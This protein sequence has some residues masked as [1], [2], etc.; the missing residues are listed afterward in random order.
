M[1]FVLYAASR[2]KARLIP[3][4]PQTRALNT[5]LPQ[6][7]KLVIRDKFTLPHVTY[8]G[9]DQG[10]GCGFRYVPKES[11]DLEDP[12]S[13][14]SEGIERQNET[15]HN[16]QQLRDYLFREFKVESFVEL[17]GCWDGDEKEAVKFQ[18]EIS[19]DRLAE[20]TFCF[21]ER[22]FYRVIMPADS[23]PPDARHLAKATGK[24]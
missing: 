18:E 2:L 11:Q 5:A 21:H 12:E 22:G 1:C 3:F 24:T 16:H 14:Y 4:N 19:L 6:A 9:S 17:Y 10:C 7:L 8:V 23:Q 20:P 13:I 15:Q